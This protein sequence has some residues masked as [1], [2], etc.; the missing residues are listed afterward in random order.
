[1][2]TTRPGSEGM[3]VLQPFATDHRRG[4]VVR[5]GLYA[6]MGGL[7]AWFTGYLGGHFPLAY[8]VG[9]G[10]LQQIDTL[11]EEGL[12]NPVQTPDGRRLRHSEA[13]AVHHLGG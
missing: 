6:M 10:E 9:R 7:L 13:L 2:D 5:R 11:I 3:E 12:L 4:R 1:M 8:G